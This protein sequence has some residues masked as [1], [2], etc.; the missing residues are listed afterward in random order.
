MTSGK[1]WETW[2]KHVPGPGGCVC[3][4]VGGRV[5]GVLGKSTEAAMA[6]ALGKGE[7][8]VQ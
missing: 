1:A 7:H 8:G 2:R 5:G 3:R 4:C 6:G